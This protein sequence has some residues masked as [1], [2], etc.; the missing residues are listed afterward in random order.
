[1][2]E[3]ICDANDMWMCFRLLWL[4]RVC[5]LVAASLHSHW[6]YFETSISPS[7]SPSLFLVSIAARRFHFDISWN[8]HP[9]N[10]IVF[11]LYD[12]K[13]LCFVFNS[14]QTKTKTKTNIENVI[15]PKFRWKIVSELRSHTQ[16]NT[17]QCEHFCTHECE[18][19]FIIGKGMR[20]V[21][22]QMWL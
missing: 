4:S 8:N 10:Q 9:F 20:D 22:N 2:S 6:I 1:M 16:A 12:R 21:L 3:R 19:F 11:V 7:P 13:L 15:V 5:C 17:L 14:C 18:Y